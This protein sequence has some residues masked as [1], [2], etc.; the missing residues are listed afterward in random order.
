MAHEN[1]SH[2]ARISALLIAVALL[3]LSGAQAQASP[4]PTVR[5]EPVQSTVTVGASFVVSVM[6]DEASD[7]GGFQFDLL[8][9]S[10]TLTVEDVRLGDFL[11][12]TGRHAITLGPKIDNDAG[13][14]TF[15]AASYGVNPGP[16]GTGTLALITFTGREAG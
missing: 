15:G 9:L 7:L 5:I 11:E 10:T 6:V 16:H 8:Y 12:S 1:A 14:V 2:R 13:K 3:G 4:P